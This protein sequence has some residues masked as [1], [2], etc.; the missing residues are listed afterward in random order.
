[1]TPC[2]VTPSGSGKRIIWTASTAKAGTTVAATRRSL[3]VVSMPTNGS[4]PPYVVS[5]PVAWTVGARSWEGPPISRTSS[6]KSRRIGDIGRIQRRAV[7]DGGTL[8]RS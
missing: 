6:S 3:P 7:R 4:V 5:R 1:M 8:N 2:N